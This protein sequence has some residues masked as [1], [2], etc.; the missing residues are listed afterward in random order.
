MVEQGADAGAGVLLWRTA[1]GSLSARSQFR[2]MA[3]SQ[4]RQLPTCEKML[5]T[6]VEQVG[7][8]SQSPPK[9]DDSAAIESPEVAAT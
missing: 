4:D 9:W 3:S 8:G 7:D 2:A 6:L 1:E 5:V